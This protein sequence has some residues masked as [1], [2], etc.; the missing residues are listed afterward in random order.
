ML[1]ATG[2]HLKDRYIIESHISSGGMGAVYL[3]KD[4]L[5]KK[6]VAVKQTFYSHNRNLLKAFQREAEL[7]ANL[8]HPCLPEVTDFFAE[9]NS[10]FLVMDYIEG[11]DLWNQLQQNNKAFPLDIVLSWAYQL[12]NALDYL[13][14]QH[15]PIIHRDIKPLNMKVAKNGQ[16]KLLD[17]GLVKGSIADMTQGIGSTPLYTPAYAPIE[18]I[19]RTDQANSNN[20]W[21]DPLTSLNPTEVEQILRKETDARSDLYSLAATLYQLLTNVLPQRAPTRAL[22][23]WSNRQDPLRP[24]N[25]VNKQIPSAIAAVL[26]E[27]MA[28]NCGQRMPSAATMRAALRA[29][30][31]DSHED[32]HGEGALKVFRFNTVML[33]ASGNVKDRHKGEAHYFVE[34]LGNRATLEMVEIPSGT[35]Q[36]GDPGSDEKNAMLAM[37]S[38]MV[39]WLW[40]PVREVNIGYSFYLGKYPVT[41][42]QW[43]A[44]ARLPK[45]NLELEPDNSK[46]KGANMPVTWVRWIDALEFCARLTK[47]TGRRYRLPSEAEWEYACRAGTITPFAFGETITSDIVNFDGKHQC[48]LSLKGL[49]YGCATPVGSLGVANAFGL[50]DMHGNVWEWCQD[51]FQGNYVGAPSDGRAWEVEEGSR[52]CRGGCWS[53]ELMECR[54]TSRI[55]ASE[56]EG[57]RMGFRI[58]TVTPP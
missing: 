50:Y 51:S 5:K 37:S 29:T 54:S 40:G 8:K 46:F 24:A 11:N 36:M 9:G 47:K 44:V 34:R 17:F 30:Q 42:A 26:Q 28:L 2:T 43:R 19:L 35:F 7:L 3:A 22:A 49:T 23:I 27:A 53:S 14:K 48:E 52:V 41:N 15:P 33:D 21:I 31:E 57:N 32:S 39:D 16:I 20:Q 55:F 12:L 18:Q 58:V 10:Y 25:E 38:E 45:I 6:Q 4:W 56:Y 13:H 1:L